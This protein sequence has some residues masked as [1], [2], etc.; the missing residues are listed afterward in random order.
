MTINERDQRLL[1][2]I[3]GPSGVAETLHDKDCPACDFAAEIAGSIAAYV[4][5]GLPEPPHATD[6]TIWNLSASQHNPDVID[7][8][9]WLDVAT[10]LAAHVLHEK[11]PGHGRKR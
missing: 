7:G 4:T 2:A 1:D 5:F 11:L 10:R 9:E 8:D 6:H 3:F